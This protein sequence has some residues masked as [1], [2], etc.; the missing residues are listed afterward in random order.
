LEVN[1][2]N[3]KYSANLRAEILRRIELG[4]FRYTD[5]F[6]DSKRARIF[7]HGVST[8]TVAELI[9]SWLKDV[10]RA[11]PH[12]TYRAYRKSCYATLVPAL[13]EIRARDLSPE[14]IR[15]M[16]RSKDVTLK[17][18]R[19]DLTPLRAVLDQAL[20]DR[21]IETNPVNGIKVSRLV[22][23]ARR[24]TYEVDPFSTEEIL[25]LL[26]VADEF[27]P[28]WSPYW[29]FAFF[30]GIRTSE[31]YGLKWSDF[32]WK[33]MAFRVQRA[34]VERQEKETKTDSSNRNVLLLP[35]A[36]KAA[37]DQ[38]AH[39]FTWSDY[40]FI[41]PRTRRPFCDYEETAAVFKWLQKKAGIRYR[42]QY[43]TRHTYA[44]HLLSGGEN[45]YRVAAQ[46]GH[47]SVEMV[48]RVYG[49]WV[50]QGDREKQSVF[51]SDFGN[52]SV[53]NGPQTAREKI[54]GS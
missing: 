26:K 19:N 15:E 8:V 30:S 27:R 53:Q 35:M 28:G 29:Q 18:I 3:L 50:E 11:Y 48:M 20:A 32:A 13:G 39:T 24:S 14:H 45:P 25:E 41:N 40:V 2:H 44:S 10:E 52:F 31:Q 37:L 49:K 1:S 21:V 7:G 33:E 4:T 5:Y 43:Q 42:N 36:H 6:P 16:I 38:K 22:S 47:K 12:S 51:I 17:T 34:V 54:E 46:L 23:R 9:E